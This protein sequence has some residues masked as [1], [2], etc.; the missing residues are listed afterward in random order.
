LAVQ[1]DFV[2]LTKLLALQGSFSPVGAV[3]SLLQ[4]TSQSQFEL[5]KIDIRVLEKA[6]LF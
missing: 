6:E 1:V 5:L 2:S 4:N 3:G